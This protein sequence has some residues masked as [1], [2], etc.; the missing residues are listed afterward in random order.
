MIREFDSFVP[1]ADVTRGDVSITATTSGTMP[2]TAISNGSP[3]QGTQ[4]AANRGNTVN[5]LKFPGNTGMGVEYRDQLY[6]D[7]DS[8]ENPVQ[9]NYYS[10]FAPD[11]NEIEFYVSN[12][13]TVGQ[14]SACGPL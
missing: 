1:T 11:G 7:P 5:M 14:P 12:Q 6:N 8:T 13:G 4:C 2:A 9:V 10:G 3:T